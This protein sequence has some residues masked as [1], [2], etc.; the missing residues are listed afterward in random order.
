MKI[1]VTNQDVLEVM[2]LLVSDPQVAS[3]LRFLE[4]DN[5]NTVR[6]QME[7]AAIPAPTFGEEKRGEFYLSRLG[8]LGLDQLTRDAV[9][10]VYG[11]WRGT[12]QGPTLAV[13]A[14]LDT[15]F[16]VDTPLAPQIVEGKIHGPGIADNSRGLATVLTLLRAF[17]HAELAATGDIIFGATVCEEGLGDLRGVKAFCQDF[18]ELDGFIALEPGLHGLVTYECTGSTRYR[19]KYNGPGGHSFN[20]FGQPSAVH[21]LGR[22]IAQIADLQVPSDPKTTFTVGVVQGGRSVNS[23]A[24]EAEMLVDLRSTSA[25]SLSELEAEV[26]RLV[27]KGAEDENG[28]WETDGV[29]V[30]AERVGNRPA[31]RQSV[32]QVIVQ[33]AAAAGKVLGITPFTQG[34]K[35]TDANVPLS[36]GVPSVTLGCAGAFGGVHSLQEWFDP[37]N[38]FFGPQQILL[39][40]LGLV[41]YAGHSKPLLKEGMIDR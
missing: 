15:V 17:S 30:T 37:H 11:I 35:G 38:A 14:H 18:P 2:S 5:E 12:G 29:T 7:I 22:S 41:G 16:P 40:I 24:A 13:F 10:N 36:L 3:A 8:G 39:T 28:R 25:Q 27:Q 32:D 34:P 19:V 33:T 20:D 4:G 26:V 9:G 31:G 21:A 1:P 6:Q 23:L